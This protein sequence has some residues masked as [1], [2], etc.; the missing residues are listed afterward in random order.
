MTMFDEF[1]GS[2]FFSMFF[3][4]WGVAMGSSAGG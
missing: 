2:I 1:G 4:T 3:E